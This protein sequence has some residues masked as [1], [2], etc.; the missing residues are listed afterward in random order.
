M[1]ATVL[2]RPPAIAPMVNE[3]TFAIAFCAIALFAL[4]SR[5]PGYVHHDT[6]EIAMW[7]Q[8]GWPVG[9]P[10][11]PPLLPWLFRALSYVTPLN[12]ISLSLLAS[13]N[14]V[15]G[16]WA[17]WRIARDYLD[18]ERAA[19]AL[20][21]YALAPTGTFMALKLNHN[22]ILVSLWPLTMLAFSR[23]LRAESTR[24]SMVWGIAFGI[25]AACAML[26][27]YYSGVLLACCFA[28]SL[29]SPNRNRFYA[30]PGG[31]LAVATFIACMTPHAAWFVSHDASTLSYA[32]QEGEPESYP[33]ARFV[34]LAPVGLL[35]P[36]AALWLL[37][38]SQP[39]SANAL[40]RS[41]ANI[42]QRFP[43]LWVL[44]LGPYALTTALIAVFHLRGASSWALPDF[45]LAP[46]LMA[47]LAPP[48]T[49]LTRARGRS[50]MIALL[51]LVAT[52]GPLVTLTS[53]VLGDANTVEPRVEVALAA[54]KIAERTTGR[55][56]SI[57]TGD[58]QSA[59]AAALALPSHPTVMSNFS[60]GSAPWIT[61][62]NI[63]TTGLVAICRPSYSGCDR[64][65]DELRFN[66]AQAKLIGGAFSCRFTLTRSLLGVSGKPL[67]VTV[68]TF[69][70]A[71]TSITPDAANEAC[72]TA[73]PDAI[74]TRF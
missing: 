66:L 51:A 27:K 35:L 30:H 41:P 72:R 46:I 15:L 69:L 34:F 23:C 48:L 33:V 8:L 47:A 9:L 71:G 19:L 11:H 70:P 16:A 36:S 53:F 44:T 17:V 74:A 55:P 32:L 61:P 43:E 7:S 42:A 6:A 21:L 22:A 1:T 28:A 58:P 52:A 64:H 24:A 49:G 45:A 18:E 67:T 20:A 10:K 2:D 37:R 40:Q 38:R 59:N 60:L 14:I 62:A 50:V 56:P 31:Y 12:W 54:A 29:V 63:S 3:G 4:T 39:L 65:A 57:V 73:S 25:M 68:T 26:A 5:Y 13:A